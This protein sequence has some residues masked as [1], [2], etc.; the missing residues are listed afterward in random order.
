MDRPEFVCVPCIDAPPR[1][2]SG[3]CRDVPG[4]QLIHRVTQGWQMIFS[5]LKTLLETGRALPFEWN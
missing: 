4:S 3:T 1:L 5:S 2:L